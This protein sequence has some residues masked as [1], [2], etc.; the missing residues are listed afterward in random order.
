VAALL[1]VGFLGHSKVR[2]ARVHAR[3]RAVRY[4]REAA[5]RV[6]KFSGEWQAMKIL[7]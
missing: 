1:T 5:W 6:A 7:D 3:V 2:P 4:A